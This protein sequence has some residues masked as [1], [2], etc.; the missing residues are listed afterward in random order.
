MVRASLRSAIAAAGMIK[1][2]IGLMSGVAAL[3]GFA[4]FD[5]LFPPRAFAAAAGVFF[6]ASAGT[7]LN[8]YQDR[9]VDALMARTMLRPLPS[10]LLNGRQALVLSLALLSAGAIF[11]Y[12]SAAGIRPLLAGL[13]A[14]FL[15]NGVY[16]PLKKKTALAFFP[17]LICGMAPPLVGWLA[18]GGPLC[19]V[20]IAYLMMLYGLWQVPHTWLIYLGHREDFRRSGMPSVVMRLSERQI[21]QLSS[22]WALHF[23]LLCLIGR[24]FSLYNSLFISLFVMIN[25]VAVSAIFLSVFFTRGKSF[26]CRFLFHCINVSILI[27]S[28][29]IIIDP[30]L[31][32]TCGI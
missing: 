17:G 8:C 2:P 1:P 18:A 16:T 12:R 20:K 25:A 3:L 30:V 7:A 27:V 31:Y 32:S 29:C 22:V 6:L 4:A 14:L 26:S 21:K 15:Y 5:P 23:A 24:F 9:H 13:G 19:S 28:A 11:L 10:G